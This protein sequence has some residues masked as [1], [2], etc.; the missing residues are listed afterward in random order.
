MKEKE[1]EQGIRP[2][3]QGKKELRPKEIG[4][5]DEGLLKDWGAPGEGNYKVLDCPF[6]KSRNKTQGTSIG[7]GE[8]GGKKTGKHQVSA[9]K[10]DK[11]EGK[12]RVRVRGGKA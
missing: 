8:S 4:F 6:T 1:N 7:G 5:I 9:L 3:R 2:A 12:N 11:K 10:F